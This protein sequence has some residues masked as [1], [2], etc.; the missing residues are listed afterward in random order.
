MN[1]F[2][3]DVRALGRDAGRGVDALPKLGLRLIRAGKEGLA[4]DDKK[5]VHDAY[6]TYVGQLSRKRIHVQTVENRAAQVSK[7][8]QFKLLGEVQ[9]F[10]GEETGDRIVELYRGLVDAGTKTVS[11]YAAY[12]AAARVAN[13]IEADKNRTGGPSDEELQAAMLPKDKKAK[14]LADVIGGIAADLEH[15]QTGERRDGIVCQ[16]QEV[17]DACDSLRKWL[18]NFTLASEFAALQAKCAEMGVQLSRS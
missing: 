12:V 17:I 10:D 8:N 9:K 16:D 14:T 2:N 5:F 13:A 7:L 15:L 4:K 11:C 6:D 18:A 3:K 1:D